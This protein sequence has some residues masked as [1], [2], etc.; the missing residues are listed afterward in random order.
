MRIFK[1]L[2]LIAAL[3]LGASGASAQ[4]F[5]MTA[6]PAPFASPVAACSLPGPSVP[7]LSAALTPVLSPALFAPAISAT[8]V[9]ALAAAALP[10]PAS[11]WSP[12]I[13][14][15][16]P[17]PL[18]AAALESGHDG[19]MFDGAPVEGPEGESV[20]PRLVTVDRPVVRLPLQAAAVRAAVERA[21]PALRESVALGSWNGA[22]TTLDESCCGDAAPKLAALLRERGIPARLVEA[23]LHYYVIL[24][25]PEGQL[26]V[27]PTVR[28]FFGKKGAPPGVP[29]VFV[30][31]IGELIGLFERYKAAKTT[32]Y[33]VQRIYFSEARTREEYLRKIEADIRLGGPRDLEPLR[34]RLGL[35]PSSPAKPDAPRL[36]VL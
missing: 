10:A 6:A 21:L 5:R 7:A 8:P 19:A 1:A 2:R 30:G 28:Q 22:N 18:A 24:E 16:A 20:S 27:D 34:R 23:E 15:V 31:T 25:L 13:L 35:P 12:R 33:D 14:S 9:P 32:R 3:A 17:A 29:A 11:A 26:V 36:I 4:T